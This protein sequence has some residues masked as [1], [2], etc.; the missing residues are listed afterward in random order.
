M[1]WDW[2][3]WR[4]AGRNRA[5]DSIKWYYNRYYKPDADKLACTLYRERTGV[6]MRTMKMQMFRV[7]TVAGAFEADD[8]DWGSPD[9]SGEQL[10]LFYRDG[11]I[12]CCI[13]I[14]EV[15]EIVRLSFSEMASDMFREVVGWGAYSGTVF[16][17]KTVA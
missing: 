16:T 7:V 6:S 15:D 11:K 5:N 1:L 3:C 8:F 9:E 14:E 17:N 2:L 12:M 13:P 10:L 4:L